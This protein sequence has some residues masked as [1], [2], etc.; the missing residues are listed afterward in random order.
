MPDGGADAWKTPQPAVTPAP[1]AVRT[2]AAAA[3]AC[4]F[5]NSLL[6]LP[7]TAVFSPCKGRR[8]RGNAEWAG[9]YGSAFLTLLARPGRYD[10]RL[11]G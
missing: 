6:F 9:K 1:A 2:A 8:K 10:A 5:A 4:F 3:A 7:L 11:E